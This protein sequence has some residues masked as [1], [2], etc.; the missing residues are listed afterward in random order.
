MVV[1]ATL[2]WENLDLR[3][4]VPE[5]ASAPAS[6]PLPV[7]APAPRPAGG[8]FDVLLFRSPRSAA[9]FPDPDHYPGVVTAWRE[10][11]TSAGGRI[12]EISSAEELAAASPDQLLVL[13][14][15][16][17]LTGEEREALI[18]HLDAGGSVVADWALGAR[19][20]SCRWRGWQVVAG[21]TASPVVRE[22][23]PRDA[24]FYT[25]PTGLPL[26][27][28]LDPGTRVELRPDPSLA[29][30]TIGARVYWSD[31][32]LN[33]APDETDGV[34]DAAAVVRRT[35]AGGRVAWFGFRVGQGAT[36]RDSVLLAR[37]VRNGI[38]WAAGRPTAELSPWPG[39]Q[40]SALVV[41]VGVESQPEHAI[42]TAELLKA[43]GVPATWFAVSRH[44]SH[45]GPLGRVL[46]SAG[47]IGA[48]TPDQGPVVGLPP[49]DQRVRLRRAA[50]ELEAWAGQRPV[51]FRPTEEAFDAAT[52]DV[53]YREGGRYLVGLNH[54]RS[55]S[56]EIHAVAG[57]DNGMVLLPRLV[58]DDYNV[59][60]QD[61][62]LRSERL[63]D[64]YALGMGKLHAL[65]G[66]AVVSA[67][68]QILDSDNRRR[69]LLSAAE[70][71]RGQ[72]GWWVAEGS[73]VASWWRARS[74][75]QVV[76]VQ[77]PGPDRAGDGGGDVGGARGEGVPGQTATAGELDVE[78][79]GKVAVPPTEVAFAV[80]A[81][82]EGLTGGW[83]ELF[84]P[85]MEGRVPLLD[86][87]PVAYEKTPWGVRVP[88]GTLEPQGR[89]E[90]RMVSAPTPGVAASG[91]R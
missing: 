79:A 36:P 39:G 17:C 82:D 75:A 47:E 59:F 48:Q 60:V 64:A 62:A 86:D 78:G 42:P 11:L 5:L 24:L 74:L 77:D 30:R 38:L 63:M 52:V 12:R 73:E 67:H 87:A 71:A 55:A 88:L 89:S 85:G 35:E 41:A 57:E 76:P 58:K 14:E 51:G 8:D 28:G 91:P 49:A 56:P 18:G 70:F 31:W 69:A 61:G 10:L 3:R 13:P 23:P 25:I 2:L 15:T 37:T 81:S 22:I 16:A 44:V 6:P 46:A 83:L 27:P 66:L 9:Y 4:V 80:A 50:S 1:A 43:E 54:G 68:T 29:V 45:S 32:A 33:A 20:G 34:A 40:Q 19:D 7:L 65:G 53:W 72:E 26:T 84:L 21:I 90:V